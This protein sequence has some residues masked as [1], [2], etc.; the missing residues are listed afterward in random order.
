M[1]KLII[2]SLLFGLLFPAFLTAGGEQESA[3]VSAE[4]TTIEVWSWRGEDEEGYNQIFDIFEGSHP[5]ISVEFRT[6]KNTEYNTVLA[7][8]LEGGQGPDLMQLRAYGG[9][10]RYTAFLMPLG[11]KIDSLKDFSD[12]SIAS[13]SGYEDGVIYGVPFANQALGIFYNKRIFRENGVSVPTTWDEFISLMDTLKAN[14]VTPLA[15]GGQAAWMLEIMF[16]T[17]GPNFYGGNDFYE[18]VVAGDT[19]FTDP[20]FI[21]A[22]EYM[23]T[24]VPYMPRGF[25]GLDFA[26]MQANFFTEQAAM[27]IGGSFESSN[28]QAQNPDLEIGVFAAPAPA[29]QPAYIGTWADG[30]YGVNETTEHPEAAVELAR[31]MAGQ[32]FGTMFANMLGQISPIPGVSIDSAKAPVLS[33]FTEMMEDHETTPYIMLVG[34]RWDQPTG[35]VALQNALQG[36]MQGDMTPR[37]VAEEVQSQIAS[38]YEPFQN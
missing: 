31:F 36:M 4:K 35:S 28:F 33:Q 12:S 2:L 3:G 16:G 29:G 19:T 10:Q 13:A 30:S 27:Y 6:V 9:L 8:A 25:M 20:R 38:W 14:G 26:S 15:N 11:D 18:E 17:I 37:E 1:K 32:E 24:L 34:F 23:K 21:R 7:T 5:N 22:L